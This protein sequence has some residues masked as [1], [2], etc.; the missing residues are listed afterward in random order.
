MNT[1]KKYTTPSLEYFAM[2]TETFIA[3]SVNKNDAPAGSGEAGGG[4]GG[5]TGSF[6][7]RAKSSSWGLWD[8]TD[9]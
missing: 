2:M 7:D 4:I 6:G 3:M 9:Y 5:S 8:D 1:K